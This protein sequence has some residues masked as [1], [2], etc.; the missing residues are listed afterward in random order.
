LK[1]KVVFCFYT[2]DHEINLGVGFM[3]AALKQN[4]IDT[5]LVIYRDVPGKEIDTPESVVARII[6]KNPTVVAF[7]V[8]TFHWRRI[9]E[10]I[11]L[12]RETYEGVILVGGYK[13]ILS[14]EEVLEH[15][16]IDGICVGEGELPLIRSVTAYDKKN[17]APEIEGMVFRDQRDRPAAFQSPWLV[18][19]LDD[20]PFLDYEIFDS[21]GAGGLSRMHLGA[22]A[23]GGIFSLP[24]VV[25]RGCP[26]KCTYCCNSALVDRYGGMKAYLRKYSIESAIA[27]VKGVADKYKP[28]MI[29]FFDETFIRNRGWVKEFCAIYREQIGVPFMIMARID[30]LDDELVSSLAESGLK[31]VLFGLESGDEEYRMKYLNRKMKDATIKEGSRL[32]KKYGIMI[33]TFNMFGMPFETRDTV[34]KTFDLNAVIEPDAAFSFIYQPLPG[35]ELARLSLKNNLSAKTDLDRWDLRSPSLDTSELPASYVA[36]KVEE[37]QERFANA[38]VVGDFYEKLKHSIYQGRL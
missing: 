2:N 31:L 32:L 27:N 10:V 15:P 33:A 22:M 25:G 9:K 16:G 3:S 23:P 36:G 8:M 34:E 21:E 17:P 37:F 6:A 14:P 4:G 24:V 20:Y 12:L 19:K 35:T 26:Y 7:S 1:S 11:S 28:E 18:E 5:E 30:T 38:K 13:A 29:E